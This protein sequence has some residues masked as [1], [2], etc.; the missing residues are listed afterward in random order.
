M[1]EQKN[2]SEEQK[3]NKNKFSIPLAII[4]VGFIVALAIVYV[5]GPK[6]ADISQTAE[7]DKQQ[8]PEDNNLE[9]TL[10][11]TFTFDANHRVCAEDN[12]PVIRLFSTTW[13]PHCT[14]IKN[15]YDSVV[16]EYE[17]AGKIKAYHWEVDTG[18]NTLT[19]EIEVEVPESELAIYEEFNPN[20]SI[21][22]FV[23]G[24]K[25]SR[26]GNGY[27]SQDD[28]IAEEAEFRKIIEE[29]INEF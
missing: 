11:G 14:W 12:K 9:Q 8:E 21:P 10:V 18:D 13:C 20:G 16:L 7:T 15:T 19:N 27:E 29:L 17:K 1:Q 24:C 28:L 2:N 3:S 22:T 25:Y 26:I 23:F 5:S 6:Q 4:A